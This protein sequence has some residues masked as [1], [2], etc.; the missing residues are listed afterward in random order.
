M[1]AFRFVSAVFFAILATAEN[2]EV[3]ENPTDKKLSLA[4]IK[5]VA[6]ISVDGVPNDGPLTTSTRAPTAEAIPEKLPK[7]PEELQRIE[8]FITDL[9]GEKKPR[10]KYAESFNLNGTSSRIAKLPQINEAMWRDTE[11]LN[12]LNEEDIYQAFL[13]VLVESPDLT[14]PSQTYYDPHTQR[15][16]RCG[17]FTTG[18]EDAFFF[19]DMRGAFGVA[20]GLGGT[21]ADSAPFAKD[22]CAFA[23]EGS[24]FYGL[25]GLGHSPKDPELSNSLVREAH[26]LAQEKAANE[27]TNADGDMASTF[28]IGMVDESN[29]LMTS[30]L[31]DSGVSLYRR[32]SESRFIR[33]SVMS[34]S[35]M[36]VAFN[37]PV[38]LDSGRESQMGPE[39]AESMYAPVEE[40]DLIFAATDGVYD[41][42]FEPEIAA[43]FTRSVSPR[44]SGL[45]VQ[46]EDDLLTT[47]NEIPWQVKAFGDDDKTDERYATPPDLL[48]KY[49]VLAARWRQANSE[50]MVP[51]VIGA[52][53]QGMKFSSAAKPDDT[54]AV[55][56]WVL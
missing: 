53:H 48:A 50:T 14:A 26:R 45:F 47:G 46:A 52:L 15:T 4:P 6:Q 24:E 54:T 38:Y 33:K 36:Q 30:N 51:F 23:D 20:D 18:G 34:T 43:L 19:N 9:L 2:L 5:P 42:L 27:H 22:L 49:I 1:K 10:S 55:V 3:A 44:E 29:H 37:A 35:P 13:K 39:L 21:K 16:L 17:G 56:C 31:G 41:N 7:S 25:G 40:G 8:E 32:T 11:P 12:P 28:A